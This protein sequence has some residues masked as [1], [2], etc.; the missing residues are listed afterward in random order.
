MFVDTPG[1]VSER[2]RIRHS[3]EKS[4]LIDAYSSVDKVDVGKISILT[5]C[6]SYMYLHSTCVPTSHHLTTGYCIV[7]YLFIVV[8]LHDVGN[9]Y[10]RHE[11]SRETEK[12]L[13]LIPEGVG[14]VLCFNKVG[15]VM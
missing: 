7:T 11:F 4:L 15:Y 1:F 9:F 2:S 13:K 14:T 10:R 5:S 12:A 8:T 6:Y 3:V